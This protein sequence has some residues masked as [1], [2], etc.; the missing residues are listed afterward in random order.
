MSSKR[1]MT[2]TNQSSASDMGRARPSSAVI[3]QERW[4][5][6]S[7]RPRTPMAF[8]ARPVVCALRRSP[9]GRA[10]ME[11]HER[12]LCQN[13][14][15]P[16]ATTR[17]ERATNGC[18]S[19][20]NS[21]GSRAAIAAGDTKGCR[22]ISRQTRRRRAMKRERARSAPTTSASSGSTDSFGAASSSPSSAAPDRR[23][24]GQPD[25]LRRVCRPPLGASTL[26]RRPVLRLV[27]VSAAV[28]AQFRST[29]DPRSRAATTTAPRD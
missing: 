16:V 27:R 11:R 23:R 26:P 21:T 8:C 4:A 3:S 22:S 25:E 7:S 18:H 1:W 24:L 20:P 6:A 5:Q 9:R 2:G 13:S 15:A 12:G 17:F 19:T 29:E 10:R 28:V 14:A